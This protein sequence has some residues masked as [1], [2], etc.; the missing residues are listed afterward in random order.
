VD[1]LNKSKFVG[2]NSDLQSIAY[3]DVFIQDKSC[4]AGLPSC[5]AQKPPLPEIRSQRVNQ[6]FSHLWSKSSLH[7]PT[8]AVLWSALPIPDCAAHPSDQKEFQMNLKN[9]SYRAVSR[10]MM[11]LSGLRP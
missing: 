1:A 10:R 2:S 9:P 4:G 6:V 5:C 11:Q 7:S 3:T 8:R